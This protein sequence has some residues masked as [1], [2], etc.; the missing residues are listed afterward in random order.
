[1]LLNLASLIGWWLMISPSR[2]MQ[3]VPKA[4]GGPLGRL[5]IVQLDQARLQAEFLLWRT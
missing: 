5:A 1:M 3:K 4:Q 2:I